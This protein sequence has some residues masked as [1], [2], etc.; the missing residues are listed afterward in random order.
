MTAKPKY[1]PYLALA[2][3]ILALSFSSLFVRWAVDAPGAVAVFYR[4]AIGS[5]VFLPFFLSQPAEKRKIDW[6]WAFLPLLGGIFTTCD[7]ALWVT[8]INYTRVANATLLN[9]LA[10]MWV[11]LFALIF[12]HERLSAKF[13]FGLVMAIGGAAAVLGSDFLVH[14]RQISGNLLAVISSLFYAA[15]VLTTQRGREHFS[16]LTYVFLITSLCSILLLGVNLT[17]GNPLSGFSTPT[18]LSFLG[19]G[20]ISQAIGYFSVG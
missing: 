10:P 19:A 18:L 1:L 20:L 16:T 8:S 4:M 5:I 11:A 14:P 13:W 6:R 9:N 3:G 15:Y 17:V 2:C 7:H 12:W